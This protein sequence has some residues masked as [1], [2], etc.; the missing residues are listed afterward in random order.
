M[1]VR[2]L[3]MKVIR[4]LPGWLAFEGREKEALAVGDLIDQLAEMLPAACEACGDF[5]SEPVFAET[6]DD[7]TLCFCPQCY[8]EL[9][10][11]GDR[12]LGGHDAEGT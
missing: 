1:R 7:G 9:K 4:A 5:V 2:A 6:Q 11:G 3:A 8:S 12:S 10:P